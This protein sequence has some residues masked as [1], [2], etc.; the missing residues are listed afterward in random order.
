MPDVWD[1]LVLRRF[2]DE[3]DGVLFIG[4]V[5]GLL[6]LWKSFDKPVCEDDG[7][8]VADPLSGV[9]SFLKCSELN[10]PLSWLLLYCMGFITKKNK[11]KI[12]SE[13][14]QIVSVE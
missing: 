4:G 8:A 5:M 1:G 2:N 11:T 7:V 6:S 10:V 3:T 12:P 14:R 9:L 13:I